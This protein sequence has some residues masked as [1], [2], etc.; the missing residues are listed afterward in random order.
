LRAIAVLLV[1]AAHLEVPHLTGGVIGVDLFFVLSGFLISALLLEEFE[2]NG[3]VHYPAFY[4]RRALRLFP[5]LAILLPVVSIAAHLSSGVDE[6]TADLTTGGIPWVVFYVANWARATG[7]QLGLFGHTWSLAIEEQFYM[8]WPAT[9]FLLVRKRAD[10]QR[11]FVVSLVV[12]AIVA[13]HRA[14]E[15]IQGAGVDRVANGTDMRADA[16]LIGCATALAVHAGFRP[17]VPMALV[18]GLFAVLAWIVVT[19]GNL[20]PFLYLGGLTL[21]ALCTAAIILV[22][23]ERPLGLNTKVCV[24]LGRISYGVYLWHFPI[25]FLVPLPWPLLIRVAVVTTLTIGA[26][27]T[28]WF[29]VE[30]RFLSLKP[31]W[32]HRATGRGDVRLRRVG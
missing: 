11:A 29:L 2:R 15:W 19:Q 13:A 20:S 7:T 6:P 1:L 21:V 22:L 17:R 27:I 10:Y 18:F 23:L 16:L 8:L 14:L 26:A 28:S 3:K 32:Q 4:L 30:R 31:R 9:L 25:V 5:A 12:A 24:W